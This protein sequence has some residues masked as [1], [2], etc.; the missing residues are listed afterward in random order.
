MA[1]ERILADSID[2]TN[3]YYMQGMASFLKHSSSNFENLNTYSTQMLAQQIDELITK[4]IPYNY[5]F[6]NDPIFVQDIGSAIGNIMK[7]NRET[8]SQAFKDYE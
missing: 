4:E 2:R 7:Y 6:L 8:T 5:L 1:I 3:I